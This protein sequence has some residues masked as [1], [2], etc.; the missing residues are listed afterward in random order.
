[1]RPIGTSDGAVCVM[2]SFE[3]QPF[4]LERRLRDGGGGGRKVSQKKFYPA[5]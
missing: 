2:A 5:L 4:L 1:M 3:G